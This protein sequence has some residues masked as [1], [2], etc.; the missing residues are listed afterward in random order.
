MN[1]QELLKRI[2][3]IIWRG[4][5]DY[6]SQNNL[7]ELQALIRD[8]IYAETMAGNLE[9]EQ[10]KNGYISNIRIIKDMP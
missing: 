4:C 1:K 8:E 3:E 6:M 2:H 10:L 5:G 9:I 7:E